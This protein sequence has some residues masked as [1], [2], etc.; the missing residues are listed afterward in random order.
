MRLYLAQ[1]PFF[2]AHLA[3]QSVVDFSP[4]GPVG[5]ATL[6]LCGDMQPQICAL[7]ID[8]GACSWRAPQLELHHP[9]VIRLLKEQSEWESPARRARTGN[10]RHSLIIYTVLATLVVSTLSSDRPPGRQ[11]VKAR[12]QS[13][14][15]WRAKAPK[16]LNV[17]VQSR[18]S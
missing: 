9:Y 1:T 4:R 17:I 8:R 6:P 18:Q 10:K 16:Q 7:R 2:Q 12:S 5:T 15:K 13:C 3:L 11:T 14:C